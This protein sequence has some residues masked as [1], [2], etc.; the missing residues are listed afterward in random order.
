MNA[1]RLIAG[2]IAFIGFALASIGIYGYI[3]ND[4]RL[5]NGGMMTGVVMMV[6]V[7]MYWPK[8]EKEVCGDC[9]K[10]HCTCKPPVIEKEPVKEKK[11]EEC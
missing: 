7:A 10:E 6:L 9:Y 2:A 11:N 3:K 5:P 1:K 8:A 4:P